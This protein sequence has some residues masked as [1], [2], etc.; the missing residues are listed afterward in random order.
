MSRPEQSK[1]ATRKWHYVCGKIGITQ[2]LN[3]EEIK[4]TSHSSMVELKKSTYEEPL[5]RQLHFIF[6]IWCPLKVFTD[7]YCPFYSGCNIW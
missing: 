6:G 2:R 4:Q 7:L 5:L 1:Q 3:L